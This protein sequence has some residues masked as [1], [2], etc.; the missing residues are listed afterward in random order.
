M[1]IDAIEFSGRWVEA[2]N[3]HDI[4]AVLEHF[5]D[6]VV[7]S[8]PIAA[9]LLPQTGGIVHGKPALRNY[10]TLALAQVPDLHFTVEGVYRGVDTLVI[11]YRNQNGGLVSEVLTFDGGLVIE[12]HGTYLV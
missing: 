3:A 6:D 1:T 4:E 2:F 11:N 5:H 10:W 12:G 8:S 7:F 9:R